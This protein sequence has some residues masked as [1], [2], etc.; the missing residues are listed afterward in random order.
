MTTTAT[1][2]T[3]A[4]GSTASTTQ[5][6][7]TSGQ[8]SLNESY[9]TFLTL[10]T[11]QLQNQDPTSPLDTN[12]FTQQ[13]VAMTGV[14]QQL[15]TNQLLQ[16]I[17][18]STS[19]GGVSSAVDLIGK[20]ATATSAT[21]TLSGGTANWTYNLASPAAAATITVSDSTGKVVYS[22]SATNLAAGNNTFSWNG[23]NFAGSQL[24]DGGTYTLAVQA[25]NSAGASVAS[26]I[27]VT[28]TVGSVTEANGATMVNV[29]PTAVPVSSITSVT[30]P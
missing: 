30:N 17:A 26:T 5:S 11:T 16:Q 4:T 8:Q 20:T 22:S 19:N 21:A 10:L 12:A 18:G 24:P 13:L 25:A 3:T 28:G 2:P 27:S 1:T 29:G 14:Q 6:S 23:Q 7:I 15:L 9:S